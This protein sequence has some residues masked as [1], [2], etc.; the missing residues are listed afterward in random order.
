MTAAEKVATGRRSR[1]WVRAVLPFA[2]LFGVWTAAGIAHAVEEPNL[3]DPGTL[4]PTGTGGH[5]S[6]H[7]AALLEDRS[8]AIER[9]ASG[10]AAI[11]AATGRDATIFLPAPDFLHPAFAGVI[12]DLPGAHRIVLVRPG[13]RTMLWSGIPFA[14]EGSR[15]A[16]A[17]VEPACPAGFAAQAGAAAVLRTRYAAV[18]GA[19][20]LRCY[21]GALVGAREGDTEILV[22]GASDPFRND[23]IQEHGNAALAGSLLSEHARVIWVDVHEREQTALPDRDPELTLP[24]YRRGERE[25]GSTGSPVI[26]AFPSWLWAG[27]AL[28]LIAAVLLAAARARRLGAPVSEPLPVLVPAAETVTGRGRLYARV[29][30]VEATLT[31]LRQAAIRRLSSAVDPFGGPARERELAAPGPATDAFVGQI[32]ARVARSPA[33]VRAVL[34]GE[35][36]ADDDALRRAVADLD[37]LVDAVLQDNAVQPRGG[38]S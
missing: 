12:G 4:S 21:A 23:R 29:G 9:V 30:A 24:E 34:Y 35:P 13:L 17:T 5:G 32:A 2:V 38:A 33:Q 10:E 25:R 36:P 18:T 7:L 11:R 3:D 1:R 31:A 22:V 28:A 14:S 6:S 15:W 20:A 8:V 27:L 16:T 37:A 26:D 19:A